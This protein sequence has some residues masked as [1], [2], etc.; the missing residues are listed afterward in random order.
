M[1]QVRRLVAHDSADA[2]SQGLCIEIDEKT[3]ADTG[4]AEISKNLRVGN[5][6]NPFHCFHF[7]NDPTLYHEVESV[8]RL[9]FYSLV[10]QGKG[11]LLPD[12]KSTTV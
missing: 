1:Y 10:G 5:W 9:Q 3:E 2:G 6:G 7:N 8:A 12:L 4:E 11:H